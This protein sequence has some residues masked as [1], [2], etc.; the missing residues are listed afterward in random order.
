MMHVLLYN[1]SCLSP[2]G[3]R[4]LVTESRTNF[5]VWTWTMAARNRAPNVF[6]WREGD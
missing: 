2:L 5:E 6:I 3:R 1:G 4:I